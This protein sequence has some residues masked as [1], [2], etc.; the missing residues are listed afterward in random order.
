MASIEVRTAVTAEEREAVFRFRYSVYVEEMGRY[1]AIADHEHRRLADPED[2]TSWIV[3]ATDGADIVGSLRMSW[4]GDGFSERH[5]E[6][7]QLAPFLEAIP[8]SQLAVGERTMIAPA[9]RGGDVFAALCDACESYTADRDIRVVF[10]AC[11]PHLVAFYAD[12]A[13]DQRPY[14]ARNINSKESG[15]LIPLVSFPRGPEALAVDGVLP[16]VISDVLASFGTVASPSSVGPDVY[17]DQVMLALAPWD[18]GVFA[19]LTRAQVSECLGRS[20]L[21]RFRA[22]DRLL[23]DGG[24]A[25][26]AFVLLDGDLDVSRD[27]VFVGAVR[28]GEIV[29]ETAYLLEQPR[30]AD[31]VAATDGRV[32]SL[33]ERMLRGLSERSPETAA[34]LLHNIARQLSARLQLAGSSSR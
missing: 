18:G 5:V 20:T 4:G 29:G 19:G 10:G 2:E 17:V 9:H 1:G 12:H 25:R 32:L 34:R 15:Y 21:I 14:G 26:N 31:V 23:K 30:T 3:Y 13:A 33:S 11:E 28:P 27:G 22:G 24:S 16:R 7:Y 6:Q 8:E